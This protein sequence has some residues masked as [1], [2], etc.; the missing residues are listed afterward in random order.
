MRLSSKSCLAIVIAA[1]AATAQCAFAAGPFAGQRPMGGNSAR[2][3][4]RQPAT[5]SRPLPGRSLG[6]PQTLNP[7]GGLQNGNLSSAVRNNQ[8]KSV[9]APTIKLNP[10]LAS[11]LADRI[12]PRPDEILLD[13]ACGTC[14]FPTCAIRHMRKKYLKRPQDERKMLG[15]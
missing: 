14:G 4:I 12:D 2:P 15:F 9:V 8:P 6:N 13:S 5:A 1:V 10:T 11:Q 7:T 3:A